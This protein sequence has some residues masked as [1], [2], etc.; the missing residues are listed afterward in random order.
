MMNKLIEELRKIK[1][2]DV[3]ELPNE[4]ANS[5]LPPIMKELALDNLSITMRMLDR[6][7]NRK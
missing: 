3:A 6:Q 2:E 1:P 5:N 7:M 4:I